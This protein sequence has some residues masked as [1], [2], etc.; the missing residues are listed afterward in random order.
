MT[1]MGNVELNQ[2]AIISMLGEFGAQMR[3][4]DLQSSIIMVRSKLN[5]NK[6]QTDLTSLQILQERGKIYAKKIRKLK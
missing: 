6:V 3:R 1:K 2:E 4:E 5:N